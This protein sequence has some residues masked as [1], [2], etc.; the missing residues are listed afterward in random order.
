MNTN[1]SMNVAELP[2]F[3][4]KELKGEIRDHAILNR[5]AYRKMKKEEG[6]G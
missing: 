1:D 3:L 6:A 4:N 5:V 2:A